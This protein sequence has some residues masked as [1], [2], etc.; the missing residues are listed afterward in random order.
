MTAP[1]PDASA[2]IET[3]ISR[4]FFTPDRVH[5]FL[6]PVETGFLDHRSVGNEFLA[7]LKGLREQ[8]KKLGLPKDAVKAYDAIVPDLEKALKD[9]SRAYYSLNRKVSKL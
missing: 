1:T 3:H 8:A 9:G 7:E 4:L 5:K 6:K 2:A